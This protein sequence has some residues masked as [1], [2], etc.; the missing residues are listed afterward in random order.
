MINT[1]LYTTMQQLAE[2]GNEKAK[3]CL[4][5]VKAV[6]VE[7]EITPAANYNQALELIAKAGQ[8]I[9]FSLSSSREFD[10]RSQLRDAT[11]HL[12]NAVVLLAKA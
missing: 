11:H 10:V 2:E 7:Q 5:L 1:L 12:N 3:L 9:S 4:T 6:E 8:N